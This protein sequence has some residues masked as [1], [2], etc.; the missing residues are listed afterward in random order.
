LA[1]C[2]T[3]YLPNKNLERYCYAGLLNDV[4]NIFSQL[5]N[6]AAETAV[7]IWRSRWLSQKQNSLT[8]QKQTCWAVRVKFGEQ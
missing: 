6:K 8:L 2:R 3:D 5:L 4:Q 1:E 7:N